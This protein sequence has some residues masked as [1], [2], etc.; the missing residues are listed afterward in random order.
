MIIN[1]IIKPAHLFGT[2][3]LNSAWNNIEGEV[4]LLTATLTFVAERGEHFPGQ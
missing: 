4:T 2:M 1:Q 3:L